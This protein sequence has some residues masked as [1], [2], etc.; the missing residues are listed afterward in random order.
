MFVIAE[1]ADR[2]PLSLP[3]GPLWSG[4]LIDTL[5]YAIILWLL[6]LDPFALRGLNRRGRGRCPKCGY[7]LRGQPPEIG[8]GGGCPECG[9]NRQPEATA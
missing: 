3:C 4:F 1:S 5:F 8:P 7:D 2:R 9:W 6:M